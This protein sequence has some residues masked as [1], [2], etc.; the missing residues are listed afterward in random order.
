MEVIIFFSRRVTTRIYVAAQF[1]CLHSLS[2]LETPQRKELN[3]ACG[4]INDGA[5]KVTLPFLKSNNS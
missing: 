3:A 5:G 2:F 1:C 4:G